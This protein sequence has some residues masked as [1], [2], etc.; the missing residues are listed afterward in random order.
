MKFIFS[1]FVSFALVS[2][3][4][5]AFAKSKAKSHKSTHKSS[6][7]GG[8]KNSSKQ[9]ADASKDK[10][11]K[12]TKVTKTHRCRLP[13]GSVDQNMSQ[14]QCTQQGGKWTKY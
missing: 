6:D 4:G 3:G 2:L 10:S 1:L 12:A 13:N 5:S 9:E 7:K 8:D 11:K 14:E